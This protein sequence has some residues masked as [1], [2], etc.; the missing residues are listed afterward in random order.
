MTA[1]TLEQ[2]AAEIRESGL[3]ALVAATW[4]GKPPADLLAI[5]DRSRITPAE[6]DEVASQVR[7]VRALADEAARLP[8]LRAATAKAGKKAA[9]LIAEADALEARADTLRNEADGLEAGPREARNAGEA[10]LRELNELVARAPLS[11]LAAHLPGAVRDMLDD[12]AARVAAERA[13]ADRHRAAIEA[14]DRVRALE[15]RIA[16]LRRKRDGVP[17]GTQLDPRVPA[18]NAE[19]KR[20]EAELVEARRT[21]ETR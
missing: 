7:R 18:I 12:R 2:V 10:A 20:A 3:R 13:E 5:A 11:V 21:A 6:A 9:K 8:E 1:G 4:A 15:D 17:V 14:A 16:A 19:I